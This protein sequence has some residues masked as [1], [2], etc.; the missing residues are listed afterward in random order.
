MGD[1]RV[2][3]LAML[4]LVAIIAGSGC[5]PTVDV[6]FLDGAAAGRRDVV[7]DAL[8][9]GANI[10]AVRPST[11]ETGLML[12]ARYGHCQLVELFL[13]RGAK[14]DHRRHDGST[15]LMLAV[16]RHRSKIVDCLIAAGSDV[17]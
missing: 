10:D 12:A 17:N 9:L 16:I 6:E 14:V 3:F 13:D 1:Y 7:I 4:A 11:G 8:D 5:Q 15:A 2:L